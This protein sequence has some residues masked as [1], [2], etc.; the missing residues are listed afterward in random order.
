MNNGITGEIPRMVLY[1]CDNCGKILY[2]DDDRYTVTL[3]GGCYC[4]CS[5][6]CHPVAVQ[7]ESYFKAQNAALRKA[8]DKALSDASWDFENRLMEERM[9]PHEMGEC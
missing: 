7:D 6:C 3:N 9:R 2:E 1:R 8:L 5:G 4:L